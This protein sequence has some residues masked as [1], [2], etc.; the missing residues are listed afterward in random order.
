V[1]AWRLC[2]T[3]NASDVTATLEDA[4]AASGCGQATVA[5]RP[6]LL[7]DNVLC[8]EDFAAWVSRSWSI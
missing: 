7:S 5:H 4:L 8:R 1:I 2:T 3:M 6:R